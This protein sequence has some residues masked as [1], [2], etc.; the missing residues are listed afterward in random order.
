MMHVVPMQFQTL[1]SSPAVFTDSGMILFTPLSLFHP[2]KMFKFKSRFSLYS[3]FL[4]FL[5]LS[6]Q[7]VSCISL[8]FYINNRIYHFF[9]LST[10]RHGIH[11]THLLSLDKGVEVCA[12]LSSMELKDVSNNN[13]DEDGKDK[14]DGLK[15][16]KFS[17]LEAEMIGQCATGVFM[18]F[19]DLA[20]GGLYDE[21]D[22]GLNGWVYH[23]KLAP[24]RA[25]R[26]AAQLNHGLSPQIC[27]KVSL[28]SSSSSSSS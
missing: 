28:T 25:E 23:S 12:A 9:F 27:A 26:I 6:F 19:G 1:S 13:S 4:L 5:Y 15:L 21:V 2:I 3:L 17:G 8:Y 16:A 18:E 22:S 11:L 24:P 20:N 10:K 14:D 7:V